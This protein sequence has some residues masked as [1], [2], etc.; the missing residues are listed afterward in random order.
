MILSRKCA[1]N[2][3]AQ[4]KCTK[5]FFATPAIVSHGPWLLYIDPR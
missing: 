5:N 3:A 1:S 4:S 2:T